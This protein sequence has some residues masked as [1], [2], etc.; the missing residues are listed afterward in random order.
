MQA[1]SWNGS[2]TQRTVKVV[3]NGSAPVRLRSQRLRRK[4]SSE[5]LEIQLT[6][7][8]TELKKIDATRYIV[9]LESLH[10]WQILMSQAKVVS[11]GVIQEKEVVTQIEQFLD[12][13]LSPELFAR[14]FLRMLQMRE[15][16]DQ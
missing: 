11:W 10:T 6:E 15:M 13:S 8:Q 1:T 16:E 9:D 7:L 3:W 4:P 2:T 5:T 14:Q 12:G